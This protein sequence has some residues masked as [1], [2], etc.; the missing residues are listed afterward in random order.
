MGER[1]AASEAKRKAEVKRLRDEVDSLLD[2]INEVGY[3]NLSP[4][5]KKLLKDASRFLSQE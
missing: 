1:R 2:K 3:E 4:K 5:E